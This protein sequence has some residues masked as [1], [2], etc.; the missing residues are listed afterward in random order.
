MSK[1]KSRAAGSHRRAVEVKPVTSKNGATRA[2]VVGE[3]AKW[4]HEIPSAPSS[5]D[6][7]LSRPIDAM[8][9]SLYVG[10]RLDRIPHQI[11]ANLAEQLRGWTVVHAKSIDAINEICAAAMNARKRGLLKPG[12]S[13]RKERTHAANVR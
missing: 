2:A 12:K 9:M 3:I 7:L 1:P 8:L 11:T 10:A 13:N 6:A 5:I 4:L